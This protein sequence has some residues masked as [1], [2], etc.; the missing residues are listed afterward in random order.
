MDQDVK[1]W[2]SSLARHSDYVSD[3]AK[4]LPADIPVERINDAEY[5]K[6]YLL[7]NFYESGKI[8]EFR[9]WLTA[10]VNVVKDPFFQTVIRRMFPPIFCC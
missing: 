5:L 4:C 1:N 8:T 6:Q 7:K 2:Q 9:G 3:P 10:N